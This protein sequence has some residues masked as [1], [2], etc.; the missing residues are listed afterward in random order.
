MI[1]ELEEQQNE[2][3]KKGGKE[4]EI[5]NKERMTVRFTMKTDG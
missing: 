4:Q 5:L 1:T 2:A 3:R